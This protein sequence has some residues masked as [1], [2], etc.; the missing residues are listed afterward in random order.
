MNKEVENQAMEE[1]KFKLRT[2]NIRVLQN[3]TDIQDV[4]RQ[5]AILYFVTKKRDTPME[6]MFG[7]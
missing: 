4:Y 3:N 7:Y 6:N 2:P 5:I 1:K